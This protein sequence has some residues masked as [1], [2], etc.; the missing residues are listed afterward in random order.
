MEELVS[1]C[2]FIKV[3]NFMD[4]QPIDSTALVEVESAGKKSCLFFLPKGGG[5]KIQF[6]GQSIQVITPASPLGESMVGL[7]KGDVASVEAGNSVKEFTI[8]SVH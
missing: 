2:K 8:I 3:K 7:S 4:D 5:I 6:D 1:I